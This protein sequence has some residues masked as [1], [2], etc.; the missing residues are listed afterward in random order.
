MINHFASVQVTSNRVG[1]LTVA[2]LRAFLADCETAGI[3]P[4]TRVQAVGAIGYSSYDS[5]SLR[6][7]ESRTPEGAF[8]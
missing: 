3:S 8:S 7:T 6:V 5:F 4:D 2:D 1:C